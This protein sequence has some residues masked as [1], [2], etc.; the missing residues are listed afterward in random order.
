MNASN[1][2]QSH[3]IEHIARRRAG[4]KLGWYIHAMVYVGVNTMLA[5][6]AASGGRG[7]AIYPAMAWGLGLAIHG[8]VVFIVTGGAGLRE[9]LV[10]NERNRLQTQSDPW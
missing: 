9:R 1:P 10:Q 5:L 2:M 7:W 3:N 4:A 6:I 8:F